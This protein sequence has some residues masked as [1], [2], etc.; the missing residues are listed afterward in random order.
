MA[1]FQND[2]TSF[3]KH[4]RPGKGS[5]KFESGS[6]LNDKELRAIHWLIRNFGGKIVVQ[7]EGR[8]ESADI[9]LNGTLVEIKHV[10]GTIE[11][12]DTQLRKALKQSGKR[13][14]FIDVSGSKFSE[15]KAVN[16]TCYRMARTG[17]RFTILIKN[18]KLIGYVIKK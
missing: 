17:G 12:F 4:A 2:I 16:K 15:A 11:T 5:I 3:E 13:G 8:L 1:R 9:T 10:A 6:S 7:P 18:E 14:V